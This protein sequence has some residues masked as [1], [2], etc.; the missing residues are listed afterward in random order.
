MDVGSMK[1]SDYQ[2][3][4]P[5]V[6]VSTT[7]SY[8]GGLIKV[9]DRDKLQVMGMRFYDEQWAQNNR[10]V[11]NRFFSNSTSDRAYY[12]AISASPSAD[13]VL[14]KGYVHQRSG[15][16]FLAE[17]EMVTFTGKSIRLKSD[18]E[19][20][21]TNPRSIVP[22]NYPT[23]PTVRYYVPTSVIAHHRQ[24]RVPK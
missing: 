19:V 4:E 23:V 11:K 7:E 18:L 20:L 14:E 21:Q 9:V 16:P 8:F 6:G 22:V 12:N 5:M 1:R 13:T 15:I 10:Q 3:M 24:M 2:V 17:R